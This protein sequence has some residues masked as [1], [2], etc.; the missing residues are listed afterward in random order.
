MA[1]LAPLIKQRFYDAN[2]NP[3]AG[4]KVFT[5]EAGTSTPLNTFT[6]QS[7]GTPNTNPVIL[8]SSG[9]ADIWITGNVGYKFVVATS[10]DIVLYTIDDITQIDLASGSIT[11]SMLADN[12]VTTAKILNLNVTTSKLADLSVTTP[13]INDLAVTTGKLADN[14]VT[15][16]KRAA[17]G[18][19]TSASS[20]TYSTTSTTEA[21]ITNLSVTITTTGRPV[22][23]GLIHDGTTNIS[24]LG[25]NY[26]AVALQTAGSAGFTVKFYRGSTELV[27]LYKSADVGLSTTTVDYVGSY[28]PPSAYWTI[29]SPSAGTY[30]Y[31]AAGKLETTN[32]T[33]FA[34]RI[35]LI[36]YE[37]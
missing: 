27:R 35:K 2:G 31:K 26:D 23:I 36:A 1:T 12:S 9:E 11:S 29:D 25:V 6:D 30:T 8:D 14:S 20:G 10:T 16:A 37:L 33:F 17:L 22:F 19:Q 28:A 34:Q 13:K 5:Y 32:S 3:L 7:A 21:D 18:L 24:Q 4:G 15:Q